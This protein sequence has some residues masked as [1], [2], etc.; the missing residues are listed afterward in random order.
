MDIDERIYNS[1]GKSKVI[2]EGSWGVVKGII[3]STYGSHP[4]SYVQFPGIEN[5]CGCDETN[6]IRVHGGFTFLNSFNTSLLDNAPSGFWLGWD[7][8]HYGDYHH[9]VFTDPSDTKYHIWTLDELIEELHDAMKQFS[10]SKYIRK[11]K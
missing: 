9:S 2:Y 5:I 4:C 3:V 11:A 10:N 8:A 1:S 7:Y 6:D